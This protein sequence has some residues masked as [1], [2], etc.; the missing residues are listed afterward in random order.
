M[1]KKILMYVGEHFFKVVI[2]KNNFFMF[3][4]TKICL[5]THYLL[6]KHGIV[7]PNNL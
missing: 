5:K 1:R 7:K 6:I 3:F 4:K 2:F